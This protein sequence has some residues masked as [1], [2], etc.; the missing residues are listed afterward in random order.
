M[1]AN[2]DLAAAYQALRALPT[3]Y[4]LVVDQPVYILPTEHGWDTMGVSGLEM[5]NIITVGKEDYEVDFESYGVLWIHAQRIR[6]A[7]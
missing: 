2:T 7:A 6:A 1:P 4:D 5:G 3:P